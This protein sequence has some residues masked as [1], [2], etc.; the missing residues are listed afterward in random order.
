MRAART[1]RSAA[2]LA[3]SA[4][5][6]MISTEARCFVLVFIIGSAVST[7]SYSAVEPNGLS[8]AIA[9]FTTSG[10][11]VQRVSARGSWLNATTENS[12]FL[13]SSSNR[14]RSTADRASTRRC[15]NMLSLTSSSTARLTGTR[16]FVNC[17]MAWRS[18]SSKISNA[19]TGR[20]VTRC[21]SPIDNSR[22]H[23][24]EIDARLERRRAVLRDESGADH[25]RKHDRDTGSA[26]ATNP[27]LNQWLYR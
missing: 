15:P 2:S 24:D 12:S 4:P 6:E 25:R 7:A 18:P 5:S 21:P 10:V 20:P 27:T 26:H 8:V 16:S 13:S 14:N 9:V 17:V 23:A 3:V 19:S 1:S 22:R 11:C